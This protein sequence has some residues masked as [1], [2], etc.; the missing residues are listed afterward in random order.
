MTEAALSLCFGKSTMPGWEGKLNSSVLI[1][2]A[3]WHEAGEE[4]VCALWH[5]KIIAN[6]LQEQKQR[7][8]NT[9]N[10][11]FLLFFSL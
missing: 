2:G 3:K 4:G 7:G 9:H 11:S 10:P 8:G 1:W 5:Q 6:V